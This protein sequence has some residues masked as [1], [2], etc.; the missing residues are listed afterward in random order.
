M[1]MT[2]MPLDASVAT[3][4]TDER[5]YV[6][7]PAILAGTALATA[8]SFVFLTFGSAIGLS[9]TSAYEGEGMSLFWFTIVAALWLLWVELSGF[10]A[11]GYLTGRLRRRKYDAS[12]HESDIRDGS[13]G[14]VMWA[15][16]VL[17]GAFIA[18]S[19]IGAAVST[20]TTA[21][22]NVV[23]GAASAAGEALDQ[24][25][26]MIDR[27]LRSGTAADATTTAP[28]AGAAPE[29]GTA[30]DMRDQINR[31]LVSSIASGALEDADRQYL[32][33]TVAART[34]VDQA[35]AERRVDAM[36]A[37][38]QEV[39]AEARAAADRARQIG[40]IAAFL[41]AASLFVSAVGAYY[42]AT[43]G[44]NHRDRQVFFTDWSR[45]W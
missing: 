25:G 40:M 7:W 9:L 28:A 42:G 31:I 13:H 2:D 37:Q 6:D 14:L 23:E 43:L 27:L 35:E 1:A 44:G 10:I 3:I 26:L 33:S 5:S 38:A 36:W 16:G 17:I 24:N 41:T 8:I 39:E 4:E 32:A 18:F 29:A 22:S 30:E 21:A 45:P 11:G 20:A 34:G 12:E 19:G 15:V